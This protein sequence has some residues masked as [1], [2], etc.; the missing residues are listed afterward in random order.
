MQMMVSVGFWI[1][2]YFLCSPS[3]LSIVRMLAA[4]SFY[5]TV[6]RKSHFSHYCAIM[7][8]YSKY[9]YRRVKHEE[10][11]GAWF[12]SCLH[13]SQKTEVDSGKSVNF[14]TENVRW[15]SLNQYV[16]FQRTQFEL[17]VPPQSLWWIIGNTFPVSVQQMLE[18]HESVNTPLIFADSSV[19]LEFLPVMESK[20]SCSSLDLLPCL[21]MRLTD[22]PP[23]AGVTRTRRIPFRRAVEAAKFQAWN[24]LNVLHLV[25]YVKSTLARHQ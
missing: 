23:S 24:H 7:A 25:L 11:S 18:T 3:L 8:P 22:C 6:F 14:S 1:F 5:V 13:S 20:E 16:L 4:K 15:S 21:Q 10:Q 9:L 12:M 2:L 19:Y 17:Q